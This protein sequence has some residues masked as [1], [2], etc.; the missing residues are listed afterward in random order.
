M[1]FLGKVS[2]VGLLILL[3][4]GPSGDTVEYPEGDPAQGRQAFVRY[5]CFSCHNVEG[6]ELPEA[7]PVKLGPVLGPRPWPYLLNAIVAP[8]HHVPDTFR[9]ALTESKPRMGDA[10]RPF[11]EQ[12]TVGEMIDIIAFLRSSSEPAATPPPEPED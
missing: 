7:A 6:K 2:S 5:Q 8:A 4:C 11:S 9:A 3:A 1:K 10:M 12:V